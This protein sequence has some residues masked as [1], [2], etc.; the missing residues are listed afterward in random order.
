ML[1]SVLLRK[2]EDNPHLVIPT[3]L[4]LAVCVTTMVFSIL[5]TRPTLPSGTFS[6]QDVSSKKVNLLFFGNYS[7]MN[8]EDYTLAMEQIINNVELS[9]KTL[10]KDVYAQGVVLERKYKYL[11]IAY[12]IFMYGLILSALAFIIAS[13]TSGKIKIK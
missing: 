8:L 13:M 12:N 7:K 3:L 4:L 9:Y 5:S 11:R 6:Q 10:I 1:L 2:L